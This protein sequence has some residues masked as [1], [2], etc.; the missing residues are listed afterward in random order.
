MTFSDLPKSTETTSISFPTWLIELVDDY[1][2]KSDDLTRS[3]FITRS[4]RKYLL[5]KYDRNISCSN[6][7]V[8]SF[9]QCST[10]SMRIRLARNYEEL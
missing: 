9:G 5:L 8:Q 7:T 4:I 6:T 10:R 1:V 2:G 3:A